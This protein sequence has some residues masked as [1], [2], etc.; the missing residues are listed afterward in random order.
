VE[1]RRR[2]RPLIL[3]VQSVPRRMPC[4][5]LSW[6]QPHRL[7]RILAPADQGHG[8]FDA[9]IIAI[10]SGKPRRLEVG[11]LADASSGYAPAALAKVESTRLRATAFRVPACS[12]CST[13][14]A[15]G[16]S[17]EAP[18]YSRTTD[19]RTAS[20]QAFPSP[21]G[22]PLGVIASFRSAHTRL[23]AGRWLRRPRSSRG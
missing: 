22:R 1:R 11:R 4:K 23:G 15:S 8:R 6:P 13:G 21:H 19:R 5:S 12:G 9:R 3:M 10:R 17:R 14:H 20:L 2:C 7:A 18:W 16:G